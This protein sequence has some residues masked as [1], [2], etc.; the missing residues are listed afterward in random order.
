MTQRPQPPA[1]FPDSFVVEPAHDEVASDLP[2]LPRLPSRELQPV[3]AV[4][5]QEDFV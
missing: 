3:I 2:R 5:S 1:C 4:F